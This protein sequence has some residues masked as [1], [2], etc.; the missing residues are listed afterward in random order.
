M[1]RHFSAVFLQAGIT[2]Y[3]VH[4]ARAHN[5]LLLAF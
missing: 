3:I 4:F 2:L 1:R 5:V